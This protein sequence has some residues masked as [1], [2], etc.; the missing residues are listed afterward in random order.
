MITNK[1]INIEDFYWNQPYK[2]NTTFPDLI[3]MILQ[4]LNN[5]YNNKDIA[6]YLKRIG[7]YIANNFKDLPKYDFLS[8]QEKSKIIK[9]YYHSNISLCKDYFNNDEQILNLLTNS[10]YTKEDIDNW[11]RRCGY[12]GW[13]WYEFFKYLD[14]L[15]SKRWQ[16]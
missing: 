9:M 16:Q 12:D 11:N 1:E 5:M 6:S 15:I 7:R 2:E 14:D 3:T 13:F 8:P 10:H 4:Y